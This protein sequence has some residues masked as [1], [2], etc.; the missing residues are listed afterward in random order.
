MRNE[1]EMMLLWAPFGALMVLDIVAVLSAL[2]R[3]GAN[4]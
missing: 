2:V 1:M 3:V 4:L